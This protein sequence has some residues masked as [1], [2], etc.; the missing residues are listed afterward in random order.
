MRVALTGGIASGKSTV[1]SLLR[2][3]GAVVIDADQLAR[4][5]V[6]P[7]TDGLAEVVEAFGDS[8]LAA[9]GSLDRPAVA[10]IVF[11]DEDAR[12]RLEGIIHPRVFEEFVRLEAEAPEGALV[13]HDIPLLAESGRTQ[14][15]DAVLV[16]DAPHETQVDRMVRDRG[17]TREEAESR[18]AAQ[19]DR[20]TRLSIATH[21]IENDETR[22]EL[23]A[24]VREVYAEL[25]G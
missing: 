8:V 21:V 25:M 3:L 2:T 24:R 15:F 14:D 5:V 16:V 17:M 13:V 18:I 1:S 23:E 22:E 11:D 12:R 20:D 6:A 7:G 4:D 19:A 10:R 9:D